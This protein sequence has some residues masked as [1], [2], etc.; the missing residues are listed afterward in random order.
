MKAIL[1]NVSQTIPQMLWDEW[2]KKLIDWVLSSENA[3]IVVQNLSETVSV[4]SENNQPATEAAWYKQFYKSE[5]DVPL[6][7]VYQKQFIAW[8][9]GTA[10]LR[11]AI[12]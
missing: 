1:W 4:Y 12:F 7:R 2:Y 6:S 8:T 9:W 3:K 11:M 10:E 5:V